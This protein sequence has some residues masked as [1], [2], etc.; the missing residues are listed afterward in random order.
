M[1]DL[2]NK[3]LGKNQCDSH[4]KNY[5]LLCLGRKYADTYMAN[6]R[7]ET[8]FFAIFPGLQARQRYFRQNVSPV[9]IDTNLKNEEMLNLLVSDFGFYLEYSIQLR[10]GSQL[11]H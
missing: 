3:M 5:N 8:I 7:L 10:P 2:D 11:T 1:L 6:V 9:D 4:C